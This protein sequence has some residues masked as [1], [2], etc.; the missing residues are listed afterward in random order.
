MDRRFYDMDIPLRR[1]SR[2]GVPPEG[3]LLVLRFDEG[4]ECLRLCPEIAGQPGAVIS[5]MGH[6]RFLQ[7]DDI[8]FVSGLS[9]LDPF[10]V[11]MQT[12]P[13]RNFKIVMRVI[14]P[15]LERD[16]APVRC[17][18]RLTDEPAAKIRAVSSEAESV[19]CAVLWKAPRES[20]RSLAG[21]DG[22]V[23][24][25][26]TLYRGDPEL[27]ALLPEDGKNVEGD[28]LQGLARLCVRAPY[29]FDAALSAMLRPLFRLRAENAAAPSARFAQRE[30]DLQG[31]ALQSAVL[32]APS[33]VAEA[34]AVRFAADL[35]RF[36]GV[37][38]PAD[39][40]P[41]PFSGY[42]PTYTDMTGPQRD[43]YFFWRSRF[44]AGEP[45]KAD[46][47][48]VFLASYEVIN[49]ICPAPADGLARLLRLW[50]TYR[51]TYPFLDRLMPGWC[52]DF[53]LVNGLEPDFDRLAE[54]IPFPFECR[55]YLFEVF[56]N[57]RLRGGLAG[58]PLPLLCRIS[59]YDMDMGRFY[60][61]EPED[62]T[63]ARPLPDTGALCRDAV[64]A[65]LRAADERSRRDGEGS[66]LERFSLPPK[67][68]LWES[69]RSAVRAK[70]AACRIRLTYIPYSEN[71]E[72][73][74][75]LANLLRYTENVL[76]RRFRFPGRLR[77]GALPENLL[78][79]ADEALS[80]P[81][82]MPP[83]PDVSSK[84]GRAAPAP[85]A[86]PPVP[87]HLHID[88][89]QALRVESDSWVNTRK[90]LD[91][92]GESAGDPAAEP[93]IPAVPDIPPVPFRPEEP[94]VPDVPAVPCPPDIPA[95]P[96][97]PD[98]E[99]DGDVFGELCA[100]LS[101]LQTDVLRLILA[102]ETGA[103]SARCAREYTFPE[104][105]YEEINSLSDEYLGDLLL[106]S[107]G[108]V[109]EDY[110]A[111]LSAALGL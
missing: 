22:Y 28:A 98:A 83:E 107:G 14:L 24:S 6:G 18:L 87:V 34:K 45:L 23:L 29:L 68:V 79:A 88:L 5:Y 81:R 11:R 44:D 1:F 13:A 57:R 80:A 100:V 95:V 26:S 17:V 60:R 33:R 16:H 49:G 77:C 56:C 85:D 110:T 63:P 27:L 84:V 106:D 104:A 71:P 58:V 42:C 15:K 111:S 55:S 74:A 72:L 75:F 47:A 76:R 93:D 21:L 31:P 50:K 64:A 25:G 37:S 96:D 30:T 62:S 99:P 102:G 8:F 41:M 7:D 40:R 19:C 9:M 82:F 67:A 101:P 90:L 78:R 91:A 109:F 39:A 38:A 12:V 54:D 61:S 10:L 46:L 59:G 86:A 66:L 32:I 4:E 51:G 43:W 48:Y 92:V 53:I 35:R 105:V 36:R 65:V 69:F 103:V 89:E 94:V 97:M 73:Q 52:T 108:A 70:E 2:D 20:F 3:F